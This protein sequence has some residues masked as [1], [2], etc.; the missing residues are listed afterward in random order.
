MSSIENLEVSF[1]SQGWGPVLGASANAFDGMIY[2][3]FDKKERITRCAE[4]GMSH[5]FGAKN[6]PWL[7]THSSD[8]SGNQ[9]FNAQVANDAFMF[10]DSASRSSKSNYEL[11]FF[12][13]KFAHSTIFVCAIFLGNKKGG[14][15]NNQANNKT[16]SNIKKNDVQAM[17]NLKNKSNGKRNAKYDRA[18]ALTPKADW[19]RVPFDE[20]DLGKVIA[21]TL[22]IGTDM[23]NEVVPEDLLW[24]GKLCSYNDAFEKNHVRSSRLAKR[25]EYDTTFYNINPVLDD[26]LLRLFDEGDVFT[27][28]SIL[29]HLIVSFKSSSPW[30][31]VIEKAEDK[32]FIGRRPDSDLESFT[33]SESS[34]D[35]RFSPVASDINAPGN[36]SSEAVSINQRFISLVL[37]DNVR[38]EVNFF[39]LC[40]HYPCCYLFLN[41][42]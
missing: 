31:I 9:D 20:L 35:C 33:V 36:L 3:N 1:N 10:V 42:A 23:I 13:S 32:I 11:L 14:Y 41:G 18:P 28:D 24:T 29:A 19:D 5:H 2:S 37:T 34:S 21:K 26:N 38:S 7:K 17:K 40:F 39:Y 8:H 12:V 22:K 25:D 6:R 15:G 4:L 30:D 16:K 27:T